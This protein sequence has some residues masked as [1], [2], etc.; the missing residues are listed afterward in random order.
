MYSYAR[1]TK[2]KEDL[3]A[4]LSKL[5]TDPKYTHVLNVA[6]LNKLESALAEYDVVLSKIGKNGYCRDQELNS[7]FDITEKF[8]ERISGEMNLIR[9]S[10]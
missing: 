10:N 5:K 6:D 3:F 1:I 8:I 4:L 2:I 7:G 9:Q